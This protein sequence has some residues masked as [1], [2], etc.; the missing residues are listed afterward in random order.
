V[1]EVPLDSLAGL[2]ADGTIQHGLH[3][4]AI[5]LALPRLMRNDI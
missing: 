3:I 1:E 2:I 4:A 5:A